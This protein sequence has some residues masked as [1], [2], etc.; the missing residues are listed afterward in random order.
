MV[1]RIKTGDDSEQMIGYFGITYNVLV[2]RISVLTSAGRLQKG[3]LRKTKRRRSLAHIL[4]S[5][6]DTK[7]QIK[8]SPDTTSDDEDVGVRPFRRRATRDVQYDTSYH[9]LN[10]VLDTDKVERG[11]SLAQ[12]S[13]LE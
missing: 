3:A 5:F 1:A 9:P 2:K 4:L 8:A 12:C 10:D 11:S 7:A 13:R 6:P